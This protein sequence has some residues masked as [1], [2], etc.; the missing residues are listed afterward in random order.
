MHVGNGVS[1]N[2]QKHKL[3]LWFYS[4]CLCCVTLLC[5]EYLCFCSMSRAPE[6]PQCF[7]D[8]HPV[9][10]HYFQMHCTDISSEKNNRP[11]HIQWFSKILLVLHTHRKLENHLTICAFFFLSNFISG[12]NFSITL[13][14]GCRAQKNINFAFLRCVAHT[15]E[16][17]K[18]YNEPPVMKFKKWG[19]LLSNKIL[20]CTYNFAWKQVH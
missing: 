8:A 6:R 13:L 15:S 17:R 18:S 20:W 10:L 9:F 19:P 4:V 12:K 14:S 16:L 11:E 7:L 1:C 2:E 3:Q 5:Y